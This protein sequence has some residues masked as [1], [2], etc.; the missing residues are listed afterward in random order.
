MFCFV[1]QLK[2]EAKQQIT[3]YLTQEETPKEIVQQMVASIDPAYINIKDLNNKYM[4]YNNETP[5]SLLTHFAGNYF[6]TTVTDQLQAASE[7]AKP[8]DQVTSLGTWITRLEQQRQKCEEVGIAI[9]DGF[10]VLKI[11]E[12]A[13]KYVLF[14]TADHEAY[15]ELPS[16]NL[17]EVIKSWVKKYKSHNTYQQNQTV[18][19]QYK[20][21]TYSGPP[22]KVTWQRKPMKKHTSQLSR[23][24]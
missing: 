1:L 14:T 4:G 17:A 15:N 3:A 13:K 23:R 6:K 11:T 18:T 20:S 21:V 7:F 22:P 24:W 2:D 10:M 12:N 19:N 16:H 5:K 9:D 8:W